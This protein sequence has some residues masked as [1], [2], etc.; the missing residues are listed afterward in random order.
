MAENLFS[1]EGDRGELVETFYNLLVA[2]KE[3]SYEDILTEWDGGTLSVPKITVHPLYTTLKHVVPEVVRTLRMYD[4]SVL[5]IPYGRSTAYQYVGGDK[6]P[7]RNIRFKAQLNAKYKD[8]ADYIKDKKA[9]RITYKPFDR[10][11][12]DVIFHPHLLYTYNGR[13]FAFG[14]SIRDGKA[15]FRKFCIALDRIKGD[16]RGAGSA[17]VYIPPVPDEYSYLSDIVGVRLEE[18]ET[19]CTIRLRTLD[20]YTFGRMNTKPLHDSQKVVLYPDWASGRDYGEFEMKVI[21]NVELIGQI[22][23]YGHMLEVIGP[24]TFRKRVADELAELYLRY[25]DMRP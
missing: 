6:D 8:I 25:Q 16:I 24:D 11:A 12:M 7:L 4:Y 14:V 15:P 9:F 22:L 13:Y 2:G 3:V 20:S 5:E 23:S 10:K 19:L 17:T 1:Y 21:P 18:G